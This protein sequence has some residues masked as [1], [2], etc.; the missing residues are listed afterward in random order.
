MGIV[1]A[2]G[3]AFENYYATMTH[4]LC[5]VHNIIVAVRYT[6]L[7]MRSMYTESVSVGSYYGVLS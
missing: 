4:A 5:Q 2:S 6:G 1:K 7:L 3:F